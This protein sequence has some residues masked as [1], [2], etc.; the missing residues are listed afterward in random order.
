MFQGQSSTEYVGA[1]GIVDL[2]IDAE[3]PGEFV[4]RVDEHDRIALNNPGQRA[5]YVNIL[6]SDDATCI[7]WITVSQYD[8]TRGSAWT[9]DVGRACGQPWYANKEFAGKLE[10]G[11]DFIPACMWLD[12]DHTNDIPYSSMK[13]TVRA[14]GEKTT[15]TASAASTCD[16]LYFRDN[17]EVNDGESTIHKQPSR[18]FADLSYRDPKPQRQQYE[19]C[20]SNVDNFLC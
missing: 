20:T 13:W 4:S 2:T 3:V 19:P 8:D 6:N 14:F 9:G 1:G 18:T 10:D 11:S 15:D 17:G 5:E 12:G 16:A 7:A